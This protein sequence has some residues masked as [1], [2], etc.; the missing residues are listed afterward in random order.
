MGWSGLGRAGG[1]T[2]AVMTD[3]INLA[4]MLPGGVGVAR[5]AAT[6]TL[7]GPTGV[8]ANDLPRLLGGDTRQFYDG[9]DSSFAAEL[10]H[11]VKRDT[12]GSSVWYAQ[13]AMERLVRSRLRMAAD[14]AYARAFVRMQ[15]RAR[16]D[17]GPRY[18]WLPGDVSPDRGPDI[19]AMAH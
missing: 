13:R 12:P 6:A 4:A 18:R 8:P 19:G 3:R 1:A 5:A 10:V 2:A 16:R 14:P 9:R 15:R 11:V 7:A 17:H